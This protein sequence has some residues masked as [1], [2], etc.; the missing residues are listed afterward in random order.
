MKKTLFIILLLLVYVY[1]Q[2]DEISWQDD[3]EAALKASNKEKKYMMID[4]YT[5]WCTWCKELDKRTYTHEAVIKLSKKFVNVKINPEKDEAGRN[6]LLPFKVDAY[7]T[8][9]FVDWERNLVGKIN[10]FLEG[11]EFARKVENILA[12][13][14][15]LI[16]L[17]EEHESGKIKSSEALINLY[18]EQELDDE[19]LS[20]IEE[21]R[22]A[23]K[24]PHKVKYYFL[25]AFVYISKEY[26]NTSLVIFD[27]ILTTFKPGDNEEETD[28]FYRSA[29]YKGYALASSGRMDEV[30]KLVEKYKKEKDNPYAQFFEA[31]LEK[32]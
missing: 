19:A 15:K 7:P 5:D 26:Y 6:F 28:F 13:P 25:I 23:N 31:L 1:I 29:Y 10:G 3:I 27:Y 11:E 24:L 12:F 32:K 8:I 20:V 22:I 14:G 18:M 2:A 17:K 4:V 16:K 30:E 21:L 9:L